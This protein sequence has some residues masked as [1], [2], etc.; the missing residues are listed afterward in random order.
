VFSGGAV[1]VSVSPES[2]VERGV[3]VMRWALA[4][5]ADLG[6]NATA[7]GASASVVVLGIA[8]R[9]RRPT[10][11]R[12]FTRYGLLVTTATVGVSAVYLWLRY[13]ALA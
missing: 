11:L 7:T 6:G 10:S 8:E 5:C 2:N 1:L 3:R 9:A 4:A 12:Q 13:F